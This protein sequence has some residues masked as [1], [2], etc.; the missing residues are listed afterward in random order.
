MHEIRVSVVEKGEKILPYPTSS[1]AAAASTITA[2]TTATATML[3]TL[4]KHWANDIMPNHFLHNSTLQARV[5]LGPNGVRPVLIPVGAGSLP[6]G[7][8]EDD[9][10][11][12]LEELHAEALADVPRDVAVHEPGARVIGLERQREPAAAGQERDVASRRVVV[13]QRAGGGGFVEGARARA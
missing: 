5:G 11:L 1:T 3:D 7:I 8:G 4:K 10:A 6:G 9:A 2:A 13:R 12:A